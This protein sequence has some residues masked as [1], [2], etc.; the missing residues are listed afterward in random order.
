MLNYLPCDN[1]VNATF[2]ENYLNEKLDQYLFVYIILV[3]FVMRL[4]LL[5]SHRLTLKTARSNYYLNKKNVFY[6]YK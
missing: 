2:V 3:F 1:A 5:F 6:I 4:P